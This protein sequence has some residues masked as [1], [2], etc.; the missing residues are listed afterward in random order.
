MKNDKVIIEFYI[1]NQ[2][3]LVDLEVPL[4]IS[5]NDLF[6][7][8]NKAYNLQVDVEDINNCYLVSENPIALLRGM[9]SLAEY[10]IRNGSKISYLR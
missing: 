4:D 7:S 2:Q 5:A 10:G 6:V 3:K 1:Q 9:K 8:L